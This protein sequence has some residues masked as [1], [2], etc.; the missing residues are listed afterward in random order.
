[1]LFERT[2]AFKRDYKKITHDLRLKMYGRLEIFIANE[3]DPILNNHKLRYEYEG[4][5]SINITG[6]WRLVF[7]KISNQSMLLHR[8]G[9]HSQLFNK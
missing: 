8:I 2:S 4:F 6:D 3:F 9:T 5:R 7:R 1:M